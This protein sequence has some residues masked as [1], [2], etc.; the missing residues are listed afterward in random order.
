ML[1]RDTEYVLTWNP[2]TYAWV[3]RPVRR[4]GDRVVRAGADLLEVN[5]SAWDGAYSR[6]EFGE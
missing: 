2:Q 3:A 5:V 1:R 4:E 6:T